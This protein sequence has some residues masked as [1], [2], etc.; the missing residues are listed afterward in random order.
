MKPHKASEAA[1]GRDEGNDVK[2][3]LETWQCLAVRQLVISRE[4]EREI[5]VDDL[6]I[7]VRSCSAVATIAPFLQDLSQSG[8]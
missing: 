1:P 6:W 5:P 4:R 3:G 7:F 2:G 8:Y